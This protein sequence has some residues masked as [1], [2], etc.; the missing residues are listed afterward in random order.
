MNCSHDKSRR[1]VAFCQQMANHP[2]FD[3]NE[4]DDSVS[5][6]Q[7]FFQPVLISFSS[8]LCN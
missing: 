1:D 8:P 3:Y 2:G 4:A 6:A 5:T 7:V